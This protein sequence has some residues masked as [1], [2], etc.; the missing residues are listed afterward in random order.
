MV[1]VYKFILVHELMPSP[2][3]FLT[4]PF[5]YIDPS[6]SAPPS[7]WFAT[8]LGL[9]ISMQGLS[10]MRFFFSL[11]LVQVVAQRVKE[12]EITEQDSL[13]LVSSSMNSSSDFTVHFF[14]TKRIY[15][16]GYRSLNGFVDLIVDRRIVPFCSSFAQIGFP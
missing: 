14:E 2:P 13:L 3:N 9:L 1:S 11:F 5:R 8:Y 10:L 6:R 15:L 12:A 16:Y 7:K 4:S